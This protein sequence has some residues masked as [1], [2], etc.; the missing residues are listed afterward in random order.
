MVI[1]LNDADPDT[2]LAPIPGD[3]PAG[4][5]LRQD[6]S[7][8]SLYF[9]LRDA[10]AEARDAE[11]QMDASGEPDAALPPQWQVIQRLAI[12]ALTARSKDLEVAAWLTEALVRAFHL[13]GLTAAAAIL[14]GLVERYWDDLFPLPDE[15]GLEVRVAPVAGLSGQG[16]QGTLMQPLRKII[17]FRRADRS[18]FTYWQY[19]QSLALAG[20]TDAPRRQQRLDAGVLTFDQFDREARAAGVEH[21]A[22]L[23]RQI[24]AALTTWTALGAALDARAGDASPSTGNVR[25]LL[26]AIE[27]V[28][29]RFAPAP[30]PADVGATDDA[31]PAASIPADAKN[32]LATTG[33]SGRE[34]ALGQLNEIAAWFKR[35]EPH[36]PLA[37]TLE[38]AV[39]RGRMTWPELL[40]ELMPDQ[41][42]RHAL[43][44]SLG[45]KPTPDETT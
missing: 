30:V 2:L 31:G 43:L 11:R 12:E 1:T 40:Q 38:E 29:I 10:R 15:D 33:V 8:T 36:S 27:A 19:E 25:D 42:G 14:G 44:T 21:W 39:R 5:D 7:P 41:A 13:D 6:F 26:V 32:L 37:Y 18:P 45:I 9:R 22:E 28:V 3:V 35:N 4:V 34:Q 23:H 16:V 24:A 20:V 17:L